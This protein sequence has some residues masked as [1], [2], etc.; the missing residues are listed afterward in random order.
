MEILLKVKK[1]KENALINIIKNKRK[2]CNKLL[3]VEKNN[4][5]YIIA[6]YEADY[7]ID[8]RQKDGLKKMYEKLPEVVTVTIN[9]A[10]DRNMGNITIKNCHFIF[11]VDSTLTSGRG[12]IQNKICN[13]FENMKNDGY[14]IYLA[15]GRC[16]DQLREDMQNLKTERYGIAENGGILLGLG[17]DGYLAIGD[18]KEPDKVLAYMKG[19]CKKIKE[20]IPQGM[21]LTERIFKRNIP[22]SEFLKYVKKSKIKVAVGTSQ[23]AYHVTKK[24]IDKGHALERLRTYLKLGDNDVVIG[25]GDS[26]LDVPLFK[27]ADA[28][29][30]V[31]NASDD[32]KRNATVLDGKYADGIEEMYEKYFKQ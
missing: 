24:K 23:D 27:E 15:S 25:V 4:E 8:D 11:D 7:F 22:K 12:T 9:Q 5:S 3:K 32:A 21:R 10:T 16:M 29:F 28:A 2:L 31:G 1:G 18:R 14:R 20:D 17:R 13:I 26:N 19:N 6:H 30:A